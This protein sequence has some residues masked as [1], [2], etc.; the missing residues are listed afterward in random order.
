MDDATLVQQALAGRRDAFA[1]IYDRYAGRIHDFAWWALGDRDRASAIV[2]ETFEQAGSRLRQLQE[3]ARLRTWLF[4]IARHLVLQQSQE[5]RG[6]RGPD[7][8]GETPALEGGAAGAGRGAAA[9]HDLR[10]LVRDAAAWLSVR[11]RALIDLHH[12]Q[13]FAGQELGEILGVSPPRALDLLAAVD[14]E[15]DQALATLCV[16]R[17]GPR[18]CAELARLV[19]SSPSEL[20]PALRRSIAGHADECRTCGAIRAN[21]ITAAALVAAAPAFGLP[22]GLRA[23]I[24]DGVDIGGSR[25]KPWPGLPAGF[26]PPMESDRDTRWRWPVVA[27]AAAALIILG[28]VA[29]L[30]TDDDPSERVAAGSAT[31]TTPTT[32]PFAT[33]TSTS[34]PTT[35]VTSTTVAG[36]GEGT[37]GTARPRATPAASSGGGGGSGGGGPGGGGGTTNTTPAPTVAPTTT[38]TAP[39]TTTTAPPDRSK[40]ALSTPSV[41]P[42]VM[43]G[44]SDCAPGPAD[45]VT[46]TVSAS[47]PSGIAS[48]TAAIHGVAPAPSAAMANTGG[49]T[50]S[51]TLGPVDSPLD[52]GLGDFSAPVVVTAVDGAGNQNVVS[53]TVILR[54][55][56]DDG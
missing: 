9:R 18:E 53:G 16:A 27:A 35:S 49:D 22:A 37:A 42:G 31:T 29:L 47:D 50:Y 20:T 7:P 14:E 38:T 12:R 56:V 11:D 6:R 32:Q 8:R 5:G 39:P 28:A 48:I 26:P 25:A 3:R 54:C 4:A 17:L 40:P 41:S 19:R 30:S 51:A 21:R 52:P 33:S 34:G 13:G 44:G 43:R 36:D 24:V 2:E 46:V 23:R 10:A 15:V 45:Q 1:A 55:D